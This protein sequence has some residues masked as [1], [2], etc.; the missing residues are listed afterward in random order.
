MSAR[1][2]ERRKRKIAENVN[3]QQKVVLKDTVVFSV[4]LDG[5]V[6]LNDVPRLAIVVRY[7][8]SD[9]VREEVCCLK[10]MHGTTTGEDAAKTFVHH[11][12]V[13]GIDIRKILS[14]TRRSPLL[15]SKN[16]RDLERLLRVKLAI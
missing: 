9:E 4:T 14:V 16:R 13:R 5:S 6:D 1:S 2:V 15:W 7:C 12:E 11:F 8:D 10:P 3:K